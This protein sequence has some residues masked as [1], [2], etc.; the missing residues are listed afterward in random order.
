MSRPRKYPP[1]LL[2][3]SARRRSLTCTKGGAHLSAGAHRRIWHL[4]Q[5]PASTPEPDAHTINLLTIGA[6]KGT[7]SAPSHARDRGVEP[8]WQTK[9]ALPDAKSLAFGPGSSVRAGKGR[10]I[11][12]IPAARGA[13]SRFL[14]FR[15][16]PP[17]R[18]E[19]DVLARFVGALTPSC[20]PQNLRPHRSGTAPRGAC[21]ARCGAV[22]G[23]GVA[24]V[25]RNRHRRGRVGNADE[26][27]P[28]SH[29]GKAARA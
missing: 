2:D 10:G 27:W 13:R 1:E 7:A 24:P 9:V 16:Y 14:H 15:A 6:A 28:L 3:R 4:L 20:G 26:K 21:S 18:T 23:K 25:K 17:D 11:C 19:N 29:R 8:A 5:P 22:A 12:R